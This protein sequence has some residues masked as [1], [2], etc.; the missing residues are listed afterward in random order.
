MIDWTDIGSAKERNEMLIPTSNHRYIKFCVQWIPDDIP[1]ISTD[2]QL[3]DGI[4]EKANGYQYL[5]LF[6]RG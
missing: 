4:T 2:G 1:C 5:G 3:T 6:I